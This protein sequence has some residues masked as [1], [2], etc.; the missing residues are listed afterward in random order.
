VYLCH[1]LTS[2]SKYKRIILI[3]VIG[4]WSANIKSG[5]TFVCAASAYSKGVDI[6][7]ALTP[8]LGLSCFTHYKLGITQGKLLDMIANTACLA[9]LQ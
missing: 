8:Y 5:N 1:W 6:L 7:L 2:V 4:H 3:W 9:V